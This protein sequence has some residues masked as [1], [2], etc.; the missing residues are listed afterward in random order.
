MGAQNG[1]R[2]G[3]QEFF[4]RFI[5]DLE[6]TNKEKQ[7]LYHR[8]QNAR[9]RRHPGFRF[10][11]ET[12]RQLRHPKIEKLPASRLYGWARRGEEL[13]EVIEDLTVIVSCFYFELYYMD[14]E[15]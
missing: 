7:D 12:I 11:S 8:V 14:P 6:L 4:Q 2:Q 10:R 3:L 1:K 13:G 5:P 9:R 15:T